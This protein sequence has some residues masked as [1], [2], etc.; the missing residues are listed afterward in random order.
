MKRVACVLSLLIHTNLLALYVPRDYQVPEPTFEVFSSGFRVSVPHEEGVELFAFH[1]NINRP[2]EGLEAGQ[3]SKDILK[4]KDDR[5]VFE[6]KRTKL[7]KG[8]VIYYWLF[9]IREGLG[10][11]YD[12]G[13]F[14][15][16]GKFT[17]FR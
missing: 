15:V 9:V 2:M 1:G 3:F 5:W 16:G 13:E 17:V 10:Y 7:K 8:D 11:R 6:D 14:V 12:D 4:V